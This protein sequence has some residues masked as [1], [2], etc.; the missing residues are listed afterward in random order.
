VP[1]SGFS[2]QPNVRRGKVWAKVFCIL[3]RE[4]DGWSVGRLGNLQEG[5]V[6]AKSYRPFRFLLLSLLVF[7]ASQWLYSL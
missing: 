6:C 1:T 5:C 3:F 7:V 4:E 2:C